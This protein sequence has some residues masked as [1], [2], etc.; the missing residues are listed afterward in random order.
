M[1]DSAG[2]PHVDGFEGLARD[3]TDEELDSAPV[4]ESVDDLLVE[5]L[6][7]EEADAFYSAL[8]A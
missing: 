1:R 2:Q 4:L 8:D 5:D 3:L 7:D 6:T